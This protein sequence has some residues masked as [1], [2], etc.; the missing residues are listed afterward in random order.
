M[1]AQS[2]QSGSLNYHGLPLAF[3]HASLLERNVDSTQSALVSSHDERNPHP[4]SHRRNVAIRHQIAIVKEPALTF[5]V[6]YET[7]PNARW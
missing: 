6:R 1:P 3:A 7:V 5:V 4:R 2:R